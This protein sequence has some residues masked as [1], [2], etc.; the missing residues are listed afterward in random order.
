MGNDKDWIPGDIPVDRPNV[1]RI[2]DCFLGG[3]HNFE[4]DRKMAATVESIWPDVRLASQAN[5]AFLR[6]V[7]RF[8]INKS[9]DQLIDL[10]SGLPTM[11]NVHEIAQGISSRTR[12]V[13]VDHDPIVIAHSQAM[14]KDN[15]WA[16]AIEADVTRPEKILNHR[17]TRELVD[18]ERPIGVLVF[19]LLPSVPDDGEAY[20]VVETFRNAVGP[21]SYLAISHATYD[22]APRD[23]L[24]RIKQLYKDSGAT[25]SS[26]RS[27]E[28]ILA[29]FADWELVEPG[30]V[31]LPKWRPDRKNDIFADDP[32]RCVNWG[33]VARKP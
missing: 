19:A 5:R 27:Y 28:E 32:S 23:T 25:R 31:H 24:E 3:Y 12:V 29:F 14:L 6:R 1:A 13:Y 7:V 26:I 2:Y 15:P 9:I 21:E 11:G 33:G 22:D 4:I 17:R 10:G 16:I 20:A 8:L 18:F 30:L